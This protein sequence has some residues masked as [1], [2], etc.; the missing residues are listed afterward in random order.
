MSRTA[1]YMV[2]L[3]T[4]APSFKLLDVMSDQFITFPLEKVHAAGY[5]IIFTCN[6]CPYVKHI[7]PALIQLANEYL[8]KNIQFFAINANDIQEYPDDS[9]YEM[10]ELARQ[11][12]F[13]FP[14]LF[15]ETQAI[16]KAYQATCT[17]D[18]FVYEPE[19]LTLYYRGQFDSSRPGNTVPVTGEDL[20]K[21]LEGLLEKAP[22]LAIQKPSMGCNIKWN[23]E[24]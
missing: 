6:H 20:K 21:A 1:S 5:V 11:L 10:K 3:G 14:Y 2:P 16:A 15:D 22:P 4:I 24:S 23:K 19:H 18:F 17:P 7:N 13:P 8:S 9:P 12:D